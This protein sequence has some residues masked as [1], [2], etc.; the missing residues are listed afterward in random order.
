MVFFFNKLAL[1]IVGRLGTLVLQYYSVLIYLHSAEHSKQLN[2]HFPLAVMK[3]FH[4]RKMFERHDMRYFFYLVKFPLLLYDDIAWMK[5]I[6]W[7]FLLSSFEFITFELIFSVEEYWMIGIWFTDRCTVRFR[8]HL[9]WRHLALPLDWSHWIYRLWNLMVVVHLSIV[10]IV[11]SLLRSPFA[12]RWNSK[13][14][15]ENWT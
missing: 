9:V 12:V 14:F 3:L 5:Q 7:S 10:H 15:Y 1:K 4:Q 2:G 6:I 13:L 11:Q 8:Q